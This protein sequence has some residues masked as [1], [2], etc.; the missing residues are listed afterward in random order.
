MY[1]RLSRRI[2]VSIAD[3]ANRMRRGDAKAHQPRLG[4]ISIILTRAN[5]SESIKIV[6]SWGQSDKNPQLVISAAKLSIKMPL[7]T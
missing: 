4:K 7:N 3:K 6:E 2:W 1:G 5:P